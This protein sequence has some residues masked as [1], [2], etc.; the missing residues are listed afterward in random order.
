GLTAMLL[1]RW[2]ELRLQSD[3][4]PDLGA[5]SANPTGINMARVAAASKFVETARGAKSELQTAAAAIASASTLPPS[6]TWIFALANA[7][8][9]VALS[10]IFGVEHLV[11][12]GLIAGSAGAGA[13]LR[14]AI[15]R[16]TDN[17]FV[18]P[19]LAALLAGVI[20]SV[21]VRFGLS[22]SLRL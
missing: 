3:D 4:L 6:P 11:S 1:P 17:P 14:R 2:G 12:I 15:A 22:S 21:A 8:G 18:Q 7:V 5:I 13:V 10:V 20:G 19:F 16:F 9:A